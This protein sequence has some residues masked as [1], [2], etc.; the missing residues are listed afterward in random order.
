MTY[1]DFMA[2]LGKNDLRHVYLLTGEEPYYIEQAEK[3]ILAK[4][5]PRKAD[6]DG[7]LQKFDGDV[8]EDELIG[9]LATAPFFAD[10][11]VVLLKNTTLFKENKKEIEE[12]DAP[13]KKGERGGQKKKTADKDEALIAALTDLPEYTYVIFESRHKA[14]KRRKLYKTV[15]KIGH[16]LEAE[17]MKPRN[18]GEWLQAKWRAIQKEPDREATAYL[19]GA[20]SVMEKVPLEFLDQEFDKLTLYTKNKRITK[21]D[22][23]AIFAGLPEVSVFALTEAITEKNAAK[24]IGLLHRQLKDGVFPPII[25]GVIAGK[26]RQLW[27]AK[28]LMREGGG[29]KDL[30]KRMTENGY[31]GRLH[32]YVGELLGKAA[33][34]FSEDT[35]KQALL[36]LAEIDYCQKNGLGDPEGMLEHVLLI[37]CRSGGR[38]VVGGRR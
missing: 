34:G 30:A 29:A 13:P 20:L 31:V 11:N 14:D 1:Q 25:V 6:R 18:V 33:M 21:D 2:A 32:P 15:E 35:L 4:L 17:A 16:A 27:Q 28:T 3:S 24:A 9:T 38:Y 37:L 22:M 23:V 8:A 26:V 36:E 19:L 12:S 5:F 7:G 10:K